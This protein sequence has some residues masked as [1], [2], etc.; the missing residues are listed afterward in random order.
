MRDSIAAQQRVNRR[1]NRGE[2]DAADWKEAAPDSIAR[3]VINIT[4][5]GYAVRFGYT[6]DGGAFAIG[7][8]GDGDPFTEFV[9]PSEDI[10]L[11]LNSLSADYADTNE[12]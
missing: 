1:R 11:Y 8:L 9:R 12:Q 7:V 10:D 3:A 5:H 2:I 6:K 4:Q